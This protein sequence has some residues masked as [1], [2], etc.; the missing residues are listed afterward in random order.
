MSESSSHRAIQEVQAALVVAKKFPRDEFAAIEKIKTACK[1]YELA[2]IAEYEYERGGTKIVGPTID[3]L[4]AIAK[5]WGNIEY[6]WQELERKT[7]ESIIRAYAWDMETNARNEMVFTVRH[8]RDTKQGGYALKDERDIYEATANFAS[9]RVR[10]CLE[11]VVDGDVVQTAVDECRRTLKG[12]NTEPLVDRARKM[13]SAFA[14]FGV[15]PGMIE[16]RLGNKLNAISENQ[17]AGLR[18]VYKS[19]KDGVGDS[20]DFF[21]TA[22]MKGA[23][24]ETSGKK[25]DDA[26]AESASGLAPAEVVKPG[27]A[28]GPQAELEKLVTDNG[29]KLDTLL[30]WGDTSGNIPDGSSIASYAEIPSDVC[31]R[32]LRAKTGLLA[33]LKQISGQ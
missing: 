24:E 27:A 20:K 28:T 8:W 4:K 13:V 6:G 5:R 22:G 7:G 30:K 29:H 19:L 1:R 14:E 25:A 26:Q 21:Q 10:A 16:D 17:L 2:E 15:T 11:A 23:K 33:G 12:Q 32:L 9:R 18:R 31:K 3:L